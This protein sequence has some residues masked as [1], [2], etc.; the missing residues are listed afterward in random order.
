MLLYSHSKGI[1]DRPQGQKGND[2]EYTVHTTYKRFGHTSK[3]MRVF[4][5][6]EKITAD[7]KDIAK[8]IAWNRIISENALCKLE[9]QSARMPKSK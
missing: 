2:M 3:T 5:K 7:S 4:C 8:E 9:S 1:T 6:T